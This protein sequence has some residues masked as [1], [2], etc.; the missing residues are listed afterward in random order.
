MSLAAALK[1]SA[2]LCHLRELDM[3]GLLKTEVEKA[4]R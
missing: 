2:I 1:A 4:T 3:A